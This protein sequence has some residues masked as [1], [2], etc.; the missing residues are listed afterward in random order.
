[1]QHAYVVTGTLT[2]TRTVMLDEE[3]PL[4]SAKVRLVVEPLGSIS[5]R[6]YQEIVAAIRERQKARG[7]QPPTRGEVDAYIRSER[8]SWPE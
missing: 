3:V 2:D 6:P 7:H 5:G 4:P 8:D 1:M